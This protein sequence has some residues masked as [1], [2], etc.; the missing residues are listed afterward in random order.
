VRSRIGVMS[1]AVVAVTLA[2]FAANAAAAPTT[3][4]IAGTDRYDTAAA[5]AVTGFG[6]PRVTDVIVAS[7]ENFPDALAA[8]ALAG[9]ADAPLLLTAK[10][11]LPLSTRNALI[12]LSGSAV[13]RRV[14]VIGGTNA[15]SPEV[16]AELEAL[17]TEFVDN[18]NGA[19]RY[20]TAAKVALAA[21]SVR[22]VGLWEGERTAIIATG[23]GWPDAVTAGPLA[24]AASFPVLLTSPNALPDETIDAL[25]RLQIRRV[26]VMGG[27]AVVTDAVVTD[28]AA[29]SISVRRVAGADRAATAAAMAQLLTTTFR[30][31]GFD[32]RGLV[33]FNGY[34]TFAD[35]LGAGVFAGQ[36]RA[37]MLPVNT[38]D[39]PTATA[40]AR[41]LLTGLDTIT[42]VGGVGAISDGTAGLMTTST[43][44][45][46][47]TSTTTSPPSASASTTSPS[48]A[49]ASS[50]SSTTAPAFR[51][52]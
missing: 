25:T 19:N 43:S 18:Y 2:F 13:R 24:F 28:L 46:T 5:V 20:D 29:R 6:G 44:T 34:R 15:I 14:H 16:R 4:R 9:A 47:S 42:V 11:S 37:V 12:A 40:N 38:N 7:G 23:E 49:S 32:G 3:V 45:S 31:L 8:S 1:A 17:S 35:A 50:T 21:A 22:P 51:R 10:N 39:I 27:E 36:R 52:P 33:L 48:S 30:S 41:A 26:I